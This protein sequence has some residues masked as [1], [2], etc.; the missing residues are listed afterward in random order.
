MT[1]LRTAIVVACGFCVLCQ[2]AGA[3]EESRGVAPANDAR[4]DWWRTARFGLFV[5]WGPV[6]L[7]GTE[8]GWSRGGERRGTE[9]KQGPIP[10][11]V[12]DDLYKQFNPE[13]FDAR[14]WVDIA[15]SAGMKY[16]VFTTKHHDG[17]C[18]FDSRLTDYKITNSPFKRDI[19]GEL[20]KACHDANFPL[21]FYYSPPDWHHPDYRTANHA[22]Y[23]QYLHGQL[24]ELVTNYAPV[25]IVWFDGLGGTS[26]DWNAPDLVKMIRGLQPQVIINNRAGLPED[27]DTPEQVVG[28]FQMDRPWESCITICQQWAWKPD[29]DMKSLKEC[30]RTLANCAGGDGNLLLNVG[31]MPTGEIEPRQVARLKEIGAWLGKYGASIYGTR[32]G[33]FKPGEWGASTRAGN[34]IFVHVFA[35]EGPSVTLPSVNKKIVSA[36]LLGGAAVKVAQT[37]KAVVITVPPDKRDDI[38][39]VV[40]LELDGPAMDITPISMSPSLTVGKPAKASNFHQKD[41][42]YAPDKAVDDNV[43]TR[44]ATDGGTHEAWLEVDLGQPTTFDRAE[45]D[46]ACDRRVQDFELQYRD[47]DAWKTFFHGTTIGPR[48]KQTFPPVTAQVVR[49]NILKASEGPTFWEF[50]LY[51]PKKKPSKS[52]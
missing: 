15:R 35:L 7:K 4:M 22:R 52:I 26:Q 2:T 25:S 24:R 37:D 3:G 32:G 36:R 46:E 48:W 43:G 21:G 38:D 5:H 50:N 18:E 45:I 29:D 31:P 27:F 23:V 28:G 8:I 49:L 40:A 11:D 33:P 17:F 30:V 16:V 42:T 13:K 14:E 44:W 41:E 51:S 39:T 20:A 6:S 34:T 9:G 12:Y 1:R 10:V 47:G 19:V